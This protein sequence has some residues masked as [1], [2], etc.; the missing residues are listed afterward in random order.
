MLDYVYDRPSLPLFFVKHQTSKEDISIFSS[1]ILTVAFYLYPYCIMSP[2]SNAE[3]FVKTHF[4]III[5][6]A[7]TAALPIAARCVCQIFGWC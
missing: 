6:G 2:T 7:G 1:Y 5:I 4:D 3:V